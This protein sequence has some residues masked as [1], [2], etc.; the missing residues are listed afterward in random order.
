MSKS[1]GQVKHSKDFNEF[2]DEGGSKKNLQGIDLKLVALVAISWSLFQLWYASPLPFILDFGKLIDVPA[3]SVHLAFGLTLC[4]L[5]Y[6][7]L[8][9]KKNIKYQS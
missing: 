3:R 7:V 1:Q 8:R 2:D 6:P 4:F 9:T 5:S